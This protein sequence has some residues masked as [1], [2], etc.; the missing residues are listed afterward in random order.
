MANLHFNPQASALVCSGSILLVILASHCAI[1]SSIW[2]VMIFQVWNSG[3][4]MRLSYIR[5][6]KCADIFSR[7]SIMHERDRQRDEQT[8][9]PRNGNI[10]RKRRNR[11]SAMSPNNS[12]SSDISWARVLRRVLTDASADEAGATYWSLECRVVA[13]RVVN[14][15]RPHWQR[16]CLSTVH[17]LSQTVFVYSLI[18]QTSESIKQSVNI[19]GYAR[20]DWKCSTGKRRTE[21]QG[22]AF[23]AA[24]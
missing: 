1:L 8:D 5:Q 10:D 21:N 7:F 20:V 22:S 24:P 9:R 12:T 6:R 11:L 13:W 16:T 19:E 23:S 2:L 15:C 4:D 14:T 18:Q 3:R 17:H